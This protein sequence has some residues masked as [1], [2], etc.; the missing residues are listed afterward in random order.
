MNRLKTF[1]FY[2]G[3][4]ILSTLCVRVLIFI[5]NKVFANL[6]DVF[7]VPILGATLGYLP[8]IFA[9]KVALGVTNNYEKTRKIIWVWKL[10]L[11]IVLIL[12]GIDLFFE[13]LQSDY[14]MFK[15]DE[16]ASF[17]SYPEHWIFYLPLGVSGVIAALKI[18]KDLD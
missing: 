3:V 5:S 8:I 10:S 13:R 2:V 1:L 9:A 7:Y 6:G 11:S 15:L 4:I 14:S 18:K 12:L 16:K 17:L